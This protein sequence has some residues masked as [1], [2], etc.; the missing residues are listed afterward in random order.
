MD[1]YESV[2]EEVKKIFSNCRKSHDLDHTERVLNLCLRIGEQERANLEILK[3]AAILHDIGREEQDK[4]HGKLCHAE[5]GGTMAKE[6]L[7]KYKYDETIINQVVHCIK[8]HRFRKNNPP[9]SLEAKILY[10]ADKLDAIGAIGIAR[11]YVFSGE[12]GAKVHDKNVDIE[13]TH[14]YSKEDT[15][16]R[17]FLVKLI[18]IKDKLLTNEGRRIAQGRHQFMVD[19]FNRL[20][21]EVDGEI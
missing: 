8:T 15:A 5:I 20:N 11:A 6:I 7:E 1:K 19:F 10:D 21:A 4:S 14:V 18:K 12:V 13:N 9:Q 17:E 16:Y 2:V 3:L